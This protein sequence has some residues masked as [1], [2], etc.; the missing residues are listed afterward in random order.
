MW[1]LFEYI[2]YIL[3]KSKETEIVCFSTSGH[4]KLSRCY[5]LYNFK[6]IREFIVCI[7][8]GKKS[9]S[10]HTLLCMLL[11]INYPVYEYVWRKQWYVKSDYLY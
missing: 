2:A 1:T 5:R 11:Y 3:F 6:D 9:G 8:P 10:R 7:W 4:P